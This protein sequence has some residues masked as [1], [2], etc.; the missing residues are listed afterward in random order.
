[1]Y[2]YLNEFKVSLTQQNDDL[3]LSYQKNNYN[4]T[5]TYHHKQKKG[6]FKPIK[7]NIYILT[8]CE[9]GDIINYINTEICLTEDNLEELQMMIREHSL[10]HLKKLY[11][12]PL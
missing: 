7:Q 4:S 11:K 10:T 8:S 3:I 1:M 9:V 2:E 5:I 12:P 6:F